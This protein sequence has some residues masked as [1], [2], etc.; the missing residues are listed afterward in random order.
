LRDQKRAEWMY[1]IKW[2][3]REGCRRGIRRRKTKRSNNGMKNMEEAGKRLRRK[4]TGAL[5]C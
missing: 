3:K 5:W 1:E 4:A 2:R